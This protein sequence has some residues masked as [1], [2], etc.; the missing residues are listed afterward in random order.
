MDKTTR[1]MD[2]G[3]AS[4]K[5]DGKND[6]EPRK[7][8]DKNKEQNKKTGEEETKKEKERERYGAE[9]TV[10]VVVDGGSAVSIMDL[11]KEQCGVVDG[12]RVNGDEGPSGGGVAGGEDGAKRSAK[13]SGGGTDGSSGGGKKCQSPGVVED[14]SEASEMEEGE[15][16]VG[17]GTMGAMV[18]E[19]SNGKP[20]GRG[21]R[22]GR[23]EEKGTS[24]ENA[25]LTAKR[26]ADKER[27][28]EKRRASST[29]GEVK[30]ARKVEDDGEGR[31]I[32][33]Q[34]QYMGETFKLINV[35]AHNKRKV[36]FEGLDGKCEGN[37]LIVGDF[38]VVQGAIII[39]LVGGI[40]RGDQE[41]KHKTQ[42]GKNMLDRRREKRVKGEL[43]KEAAK[44]DREI[45]RDLG[46]YTR[47]KDELEGI[48]RDKCRGAIVRS[49]AKYAMEGER[50]TSFFLG[51]EKSKQESK[52]LK[53]VEGK[54]GRKSTDLV[55]I[56]EREME[57]RDMQNEGIIN[58]MKKMLRCLEDETFEVKREGSCYKWVH[59]E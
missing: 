46:E 23:N 13:Q 35:Y 32:G 49:R 21:M 50:C 45:G 20:R 1:I 36:F 5:T 58:S 56:A 4:D 18:F 7:D 44:I 6:N 51:L 33:V 29:E 43:V 40:K 34:Y 25:R 53:Q 12:C 8:T 38:N 30:N 59:S 9:L 39:N 2:N 16:D 24:S 48:E 19:G 54:D 47:I 41:N 22:R 31:M 57:G 42:E 28:T 27:E 37:C 14:I 26:K 17:E 3:K 10:E 15:P 55:G 52:Y 11:L